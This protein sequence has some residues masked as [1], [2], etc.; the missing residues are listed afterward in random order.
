M[1]DNEREANYLQFLFSKAGKSEDEYLARKDLKK[2][3]SRLGAKRFK[4]KTLGL[5][6]RSSIKSLE[7][8]AESLVETNIAD[9][10]EE[11]KII[12]PQITQAMKDSNYPIQIGHSSRYLHI[13]EVVKGEETFYKI[14]AKSRKLPPGF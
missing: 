7:E 12:V 14:E 8:V 13:T 2:E 9:S 6:G 3:R 4:R 5:C 10:I 11:A 1:D